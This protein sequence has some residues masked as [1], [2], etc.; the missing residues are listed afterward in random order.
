MSWAAEA[1]NQ[2]GS[3]HKQNVRPDVTKP[4]HPQ[5]ETLSNSVRVSYGYEFSQPQFLIRQIV[6]EHDA[7]GRGKITFERLHEEIPIEEPVTLSPAALARIS[8]LW[9]TLQ[10]LESETSYQSDRQFPHLGTIRLKM[11]QD[12]RSRSTEF[13][14]TNNSTVSSLVTEYRRIAD[15]AIFVFDMGVARENQPLNTPKLMERLDA[16]LRRDSI[17]DPQQLIPLLQDITI[18][19]HLPLIARHHAERLLKKIKK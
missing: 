1:A 18:D 3:P 6:I 19:E 4:A 11:A 13:N 10:F 7:S 5:E 16:L 15:Q 12:G 8:N 9:Q 17:S 14:W 2:G